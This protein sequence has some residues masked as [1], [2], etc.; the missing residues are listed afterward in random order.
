MAFFLP[1]ISPSPSLIDQ[2]ILP[3][4]NV[5]PSNE[6]DRQAMGMSTRS[7]HIVTCLKDM[8]IIAEGTYYVHML[9]LHTIL[10]LNVEGGCGL[11]LIRGQIS[12]KPKGC[13]WHCRYSMARSSPSPLCDTCPRNQA[14]PRDDLSSSGE[15]GWKAPCLDCLGNY[16][17]AQ[18][19]SVHVSISL[20]STLT[21]DNDPPITPAQ[22]RLLKG[23]YFDFFLGKSDP[24]RRAS[25]SRWNDLNGRLRLAGARMGGRRLPHHNSIPTKTID[26]VVG[27]LRRIDDAPKE[28][29]KLSTEL[30]YLEI[31]LPPI[32]D[33]VDYSRDNIP[34]L[35]TLQ[36]SH[37]RFKKISAIVDRLKDRLLDAVVRWPSKRRWPFTKEDVA[38]Y[39]CRIARFKTFILGAMRHDNMVLLQVMQETLGPMNGH[40]ERI[41]EDRYV[42][43]HLPKVVAERITSGWIASQATNPDIIESST[44]RASGTQSTPTSKYPLVYGDFYPHRYR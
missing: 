34:W 18:G 41:A 16:Y 1:L 12:L 7:S 38:D 24:Q 2:C 13:I 5:S 26:T 27:Y 4:R 19:L 30:R 29:S 37:H 8:H 33:L 44:S 42:T 10:S 21:R 9:F 39:L 31:Y 25:V 3:Q 35:A 36:R 22:C 17:I 32:K 6:M 11:K 14:L 28:R 20:V 40:A 43:E 23:L 15:R